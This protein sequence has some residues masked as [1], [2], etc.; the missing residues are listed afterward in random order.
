MLFEIFVTWYPHIITPQH[1]QTYQCQA[2][3]DTR[4]ALTLEP[5]CER[6]SGLQLRV[7]TGKIISY[8]STKTYVV[9]TQKN[10]LNETV[11]LIT[12]NIC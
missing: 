3:K 4:I 2:Y 8:F 7:R 1:A 11:L 9:G 12:Q 10:R 6:M 5:H